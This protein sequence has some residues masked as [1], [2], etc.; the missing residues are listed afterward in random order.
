MAMSIGFTPW[1]NDGG[2]L[3]SPL[4]VRGKW[5][6][7]LIDIKLAPRLTFLRI[8]SL[9]STKKLQDAC[10]VVCAPAVAVDKRANTGR[11]IDEAS[12]LMGAMFTG[13]VLSIMHQVVEGN[14][15]QA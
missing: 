4:A 9:T 12:T 5:G 7:V 3:S 6:G 8:R 1:E 13:M 11:S 2:V 15:P 14:V 10:I